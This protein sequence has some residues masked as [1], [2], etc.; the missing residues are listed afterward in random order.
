MMGMGRQRPLVVVSAMAALDYAGVGMMRALLPY[1]AM[2]LGG[3]A[4]LIGGLETAYGIGQLGG[5]WVM[6][7]RSDR[8]GRR[9]MLIISFAGSCMGYLIA[10][11]AGSPLML[12]VSRV[13][14]G[15]AKQ[16]VTLSRAIVAD[17][18]TPGPQRTRWMGFLMASCACGYSVGP[19]LGGWVPQPAL[20]ASLLFLALIPVTLALLDETAPQH[21]AGAVAAGGTAAAVPLS[22]RARVAVAAATLPE[23]ALVMHT[24]ASVSSYAVSATVAAPKA[25]LGSAMAATAALSAVHSAVSFAALASRGWG[26]GRLFRLA[27]GG[28]FVASA[29]LAFAPPGQGALAVQVLPMSLAVSGLRSVVPAI[30][31]KA[32]TAGEQGAALGL[33]DT[34]SSCCRVV[35]PLATGL[36]VDAAG[37]HSP[38]YLQLVLIGA[39]FLLA[40]WLEGK[41][42]RE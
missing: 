6:G 4:A 23:L 5:A 26:D 14:V 39:G 9:A 12:L 1:A 34:M 28:F 33:L 38:F 19:L 31:S 40:P 15:C 17:C 13:P 25:V 22:R 2:E 3:G 30:V 18:T 20:C 32:A 21:T 24:T 27:L 29:V 42:H 36:L 35:A 16:T 8:A 11:L 41:P 7:P 37:V 10:W